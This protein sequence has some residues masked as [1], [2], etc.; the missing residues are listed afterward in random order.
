MFSN[1]AEISRKMQKLHKSFDSVP[2]KPELP[3]EIQNFV[4]GMLLF[5]SVCIDF[6]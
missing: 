1:A 3:I 4:V 2:T 6:V 5:L